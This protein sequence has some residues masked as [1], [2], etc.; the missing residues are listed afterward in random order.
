MERLYL[1]TQVVWC[2]HNFCLYS[3]RKRKQI[4]DFDPRPEECRG[5]AKQLLD[6]LLE[7]V[8]GESLGVSL[9]FD[10]QCCHIGIVLLLKLVLCLDSVV[11]LTFNLM[12]LRLSNFGAIIHTMLKFRV[13][14]LWV[15]DHG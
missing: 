15:T 8:R 14:W 11:N 12:A 3:K 7:N 6:T 1:P 13:K 10:E 2:H 4:K 9:L 5:N